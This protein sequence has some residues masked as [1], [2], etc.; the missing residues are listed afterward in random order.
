MRTG[1]VVVGHIYELTIR[2]LIHQQ[3]DL[4][5]RQMLGRPSVDLKEGGNNPSANTLPKSDTENFMASFAASLRHCPQSAALQVSFSIDLRMKQHLYV[6]ALV[7][8]ATCVYDDYL[9]V[10]VAIHAENLVAVL[11]VG[12]SGSAHT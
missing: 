10:M 7:V 12:R 3:G 5:K 4:E 6:F 8:S 11:V 2:P 1:I 9:S